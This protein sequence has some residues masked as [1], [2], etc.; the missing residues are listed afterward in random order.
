MA[1][2]RQEGIQAEAIEWHVRLQAG[3]T[4]DWEAF[5]RWL[6]SDP[7]HSAAYD[8]V[9]FAD[10]AV[11]PNMMPVMGSPEAANDEEDASAQ[12]SGARS[13]SG[14]WATAL[15][16]AAAI[17]AILVALPWLTAGPSRHE[18]ATAAGERR[19]V[20]LGDGSS[21]VLN[22]S[23]RLILDR[24][25][26]RYAELVAG[27]ATFT[28]RHDEARPFLVEAGDHRVLDA[29]TIFNLV[30]D[31]NRFSVEVAEGAV[32]YDPGGTAVPLAAGQTLLVRSGGPPVLGR[33]EPEDMTGWQRGRLSYGSVPL[34]TVASD[35]SRNLGTEVRL[36]PAV[37]AMPFTG[38]IQVGGDAATLSTLASTLGLQ[39]RR[40]G[41]GW[42][43]E[44][45]PRATR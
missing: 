37:A 44:P 39:A 2:Q 18:V 7:A 26:S 8:K 42:L 5:I 31:R 40:T 10:A 6:E 38:S 27:E 4:E 43:I 22:G 32:V 1:Q 15:A 16:T 30:R 11:H 13:R 25:D 3:G 19:T 33:R 36:D 17:V 12:A 41:S 24:D 28:V 14:L 21:V 20:D 35:L 29:G 34:E 9:K 45:Q 23:T